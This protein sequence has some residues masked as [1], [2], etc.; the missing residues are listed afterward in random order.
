MAA[1]LT[2]VQRRV[3]R[4]ALR[5]RVVSDQSEPDLPSTGPRPRRFPPVPAGS[6][7][8]PPHRRLLIGWSAGGGRAAAERGGT[9]K[10]RTEF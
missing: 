4:A 5:P 7:R 9:W 3:M 6:R 8:F 2:A 1:A 10:R